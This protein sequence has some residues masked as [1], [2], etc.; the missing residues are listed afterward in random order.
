MRYASD[1]QCIICPIKR[2]SDC[3]RDYVTRLIGAAPGVHPVRSRKGTTISWCATAKASSSPMCISTIRAQR[4]GR[5]PATKPDASL[6]ISPSCRSCCGSSKH[7]DTRA[8]LDAM[9]LPDNT[10]S[11]I[12][13][14]HRESGSPH[15]PSCSRNFLATL[16]APLAC[17][18]AYLFRRR[19]NEK[20]RADQAWSCGRD[21]DISF[22]CI[23]GCRCVGR[24]YLSA[25]TAPDPL[26]L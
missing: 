1:H 23:R 3:H 13:K 10:V 19:G 6:L 26:C 2:Y 22:R 8:E 24:S 15:R 9:W 5:S 18:L 7:A 4:P 12:G 17:L 20:V 25:P 21:A 16:G 11:E 14:T